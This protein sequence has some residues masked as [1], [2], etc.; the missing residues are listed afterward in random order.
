VLSAVGLTWTDLYARERRD[1]RTVVAT[2]DYRDRHGELLYQV[3]RFEP[4]GF[5]VRR[6]DGSGR[7]VWNLRGVARV[8]Y[9]LPELAAVPAGGRVVI[10]EGERDAD[11][12]TELGIIATTNPGGAGK[13]QSAYNEELRDRAVV[14]LPDNDA[15]GRQH[16]EAVVASLRGVARSAVIVELPGL[17]PKGD[18]SDWLDDIGTATELATLLLSPDGSPSTV[19]GTGAEVDRPVALPAATLAA[20]LDGLVEHLTRF[21]HFTRIEH[22]H[23]VALWAAHTHAP[24]SALAQ[25]P[26]LAVT[27][28]VKQSGKTRLL[29]VLEHVVRDPWRI[30]RPSEAVLFR[31]IDADHPTV[32]LDEIDA[33][34]NDRAGSTEGIRALFNSGNRQG[35]K[36]PRTVAQGRGFSLVEFDVFCPKATAGIGGLPDTVLDRS[37]VIPMRRRAVG[38]RVERLRDRRA[39][40]LGAPLRQALSRHVQALGDFAVDDAD[41]PAELDERAQDGWEALVAIAL[42]AGEAWP[43]R[44][45]AAARVIFTSRNTADDNTELRLLADAKQVFETTGASFLATAELREQLMAIEDAAWGDIRGK[46]VTPHYLARI[47]G[48]FDI[49]VR[50][51]RPR[52]VGNPVRGYFRADFV[53]SWNRYLGGTGT[54]GTSD[55]SEPGLQSGPVALVPDVPDVPVAVPTED[56]DWVDVPAG[57]SSATLWDVP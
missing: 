48:R 12:L 57:S 52:G 50:R 56:G 17:V 29:D 4:K 22:A 40:E 47:L 26:I 31:K 25:S 51:H 35:T 54:S 24:L 45:R 5:A 2:Y 41:L 1:S 32:L 44:A 28:A 30:A 8:P 55:T 27:S 15:P 42:A 39:R 3:C 18:V 6:G 34:F 23:A 53:D 16:A 37:I 10:V 49:V 9:R 36:V 7:W 43:A 46:P 33:I 14:V 13:W 20:T 11:R 19:A 38:E 21:I